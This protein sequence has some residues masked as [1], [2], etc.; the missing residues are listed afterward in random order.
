M[1]NSP[2]FRAVLLLITLAL[3]WGTSFILIKQGLR[4]FA[5]TEVATLRVSAAFFFSLP[6]ALTRLKGLTLND[7]RALFVSG[8]LG[9][10]VPA[11]LF[12]TAQTRLDSSVAGILNTLSPICTIIVGTLFFGQKFKANAV[13]GILIGLAGVVLLMLSRDGTNVT[14]I[15]YYSLLIVAACLM[16]G[17]NLNWI[18]FRIQGLTPLT[19]TS[20]SIL[21]IGPL[22]LIYLFGLT[23]FTTKLE[24]VEG[25]WASL[26]FVVLLGCMS[27][28]IANLLFTELLKISTPLFAS[29]V[30]YLMPVVSV[31]W[32][33][34][35]GEKLYAGHYIGFAAI[36]G[37][38]YLANRKRD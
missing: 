19:I 1:P 5:P 17:T 3:I 18:K 2:N 28:A 16:Y 21:T 36:L 31:G 6:I 4:S 7:Y 30:T 11:F 10:F 33:L 22:A 20:V 37:G 25:A 13:V 35:V 9:I 23:D 15:N 26:G 12:S 32:G 8:L 24:T 27:T 38:V 34:V 29:S 14:G